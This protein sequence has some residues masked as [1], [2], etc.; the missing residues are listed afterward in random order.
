MSE[1]GRGWADRFFLEFRHRTTDSDV[2]V[3]VPA[4][5]RCAFISSFLSECSNEAGAVE[6]PVYKTVLLKR[7]KSTKVF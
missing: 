5:R 2:V 6:T 4:T 3:Q 7:L 1:G